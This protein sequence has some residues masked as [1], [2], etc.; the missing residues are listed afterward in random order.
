MISQIKFLDKMRTKSIFKNIEW[1]IIILLALPAKAQT[2]QLTIE[3]CYALAKQNYPLIKKHDLIARSGTFSL[4]NAGKLY[5]PQFLV[6][7]QASYQSQTI[8]F[9]DVLGA[10]PG[11]KP[12]ALSKD[13]YRIQAEINQQLYDAGN[14]R[15]Q[16]E[17]IQANT[18]IQQQNIEV[19]LYTLKDRVAQLYFSILLLSEQL[20]QNEIR[21]ANLQSATDKTTASLQNGTSFKSSVDELQAEVASAEM[22]NIEFRANRKAYLQLLSIFIGKPLDEKVELRVPGQQLN[23]LQ[24]KRPELDLFVLQK[25]VYDV[26]EKQLKSDYLPKLNAFVQGAYGRPT[27]NIIENKFGAW[28][29]GGLRLNWNLGSLYTLKNNR[30]IL[31]NSRDAL[32]IDRET[33]LYNTNLTLSQQNSESQKYA[34]LVM[35]DDAIIALR[36]SVTK[37]AQAQLDNGVITAHEFIS[38]LDAENIARQSKILHTTQ[39]LQSQ[40]NYKNTSGN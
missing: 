26:Q 23:D 11:P 6:T 10:L 27:L 8:N 32:D 7:G 22:A 14:T 4:E 18:A 34:D 40:Y 30:E 29:L 19:S 37:A 25:K 17:I 9:S 12:P 16:K 15:N 39:L 3:Q 36:A 24:I 2:N 5:L 38:K 35:Q 21:K 20:T 1:V 28:W 31:K 13:Q 33:F